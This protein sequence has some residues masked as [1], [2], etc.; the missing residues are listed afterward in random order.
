MDACCHG[1][2]L[3]G[4]DFFFRWSIVLVPCL[5]YLAQIAKSMFGDKS[6]LDY[7]M[8]RMPFPGDTQ[9]LHGPVCSVIL[10]A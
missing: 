9:I 5:Q 6:S 4:T 8:W 1:V 10:T 7:L 2:C 3:R